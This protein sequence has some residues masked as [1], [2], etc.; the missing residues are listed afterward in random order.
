[1]LTSK[2]KD[3]NWQIFEQLK[4]VI[5]DWQ[6]KDQTEDI[7]QLTEFYLEQI[8]QTQQIH[9]IIFLGE[10]SLDKFL[11]IFFASV[12]SNS[13]L[14]LINPHWQERE[15][16]QV[17]EIVKP[18]LYFGDDHFLMLVNNSK[19]NHDNY[20]RFSGIMIPTGGTSGKVKFA[21]HT[22]KTLINSAQSFYQFFQHQPINF[23][24]CLPLCHVS[25][26]MPIIRSFI[27]E[28]KLIIEPYH[29]LKKNI[30]NLPEYHNYFI[31]LVPT[32]LKFILDHN[33]QWLAKFKT[34]LVG[35]ATT[36]DR[37]KEEARKSK[38][39]VALTYGMTETASGISILKPRDFLQGNNS[40]G[41]ILL[42]TQLIVK[43]EIN[44]SNNHRKNQGIITIKSNSL[45]KGYY[46]HWQELDY[47]ITDDIGYLDDQQYLYILGRNSDKIIT[48][49]ENVFPQE[50]EA[51]IL[52]T[53]LVKDVCVNSKKD[54]YWGEIIT[55]IYVP[56]NFTVSER[57]IKDQIRQKLADY[58]VPKIWHQV[59]Q[60]SRK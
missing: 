1:M 52:A 17:A 53:G 34:V 15:Y 22:Y 6:I 2:I 14:F 41:R 58:K 45:F 57:E 48:G 51:V 4:T 39:R 56:I 23:Y 60:I 46:P 40:N 42:H 9:P 28:G 44:E 36:N 59:N 16:Q 13:C 10:E 20:P 32:Q 47:F 21:I 3:Y 49:G 50:I 37:L 38:I 11:A 30:N 12:I 19:Y 25:G 18:D 43:Q 27:S 54:D 31:S 8:N 29:E 5:M 55:A 33:P 7:I 26:L 35:G 24:C